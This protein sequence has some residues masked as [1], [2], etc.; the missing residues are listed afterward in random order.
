VAAVGGKGR[1][2]E[3]TGHGRKCS[4]ALG[5]GGVAG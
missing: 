3:R 1:R 4:E 5:R 2:V